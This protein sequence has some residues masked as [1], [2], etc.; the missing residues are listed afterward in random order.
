[1][2]NL[3]I[4]LIILVGFSSCTKEI[5]SL[6][7][8]T[9]KGTITFGAKIDGSLWGPA[10]FNFA[11]TAPILEARFANNN[12]IFI[13]AR[14]FS[15]TPTETE[16]EIY[17][18]NIVKPGTISLNNNSGIYPNES[19]SYAYFIKR[20]ITP[21][22]EWLTNSTVGGWVNITKIDR[23]ARIISGTFEF[24]AQST[25]GAAPI[26]VTEGRFDVRIQ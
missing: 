14:N 6:P 5:S 21:L 16:M 22:N 12:S 19:G 9:Q 23:E 18:Q 4:A 26:N 15:A 11:A 8:E 3:L 20:K 10:K 7:G 13:N 1:M 24:Q 2:K 17:L 25:D